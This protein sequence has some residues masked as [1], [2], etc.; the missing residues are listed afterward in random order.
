MQ[1]VF[2]SWSRIQ[3][4]LE[5]NTPSGTEFLAPGA[6]G[7]QI[8]EAEKILGTRFPDDVRQ[9]YLLYNGSPQADSLA[10]F[11]YGEFLSLQRMV[12]DWGVW[13]GIYDEDEEFRGYKTEPDRGIQNGWWRHGWI[14][15]CANGSGDSLCVDLDPSENGTCGQ[16]LELVH[17]YS[18]RPLLASSFS[19]YLSNYAD[20][21]EAGEFGFDPDF[22]V[23]PIGWL[24]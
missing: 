4:W 23:V 15:F 9:S 5:A 3:I 12:E 21:L 7:H 8:E 20:A 6:T 13:K 2:D 14:P 16:V 11:E 19:L 24:E 17:D 1:S 22:G 18:H 10:I